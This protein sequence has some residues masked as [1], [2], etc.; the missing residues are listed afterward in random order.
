[1]GFWD[2]EKSAKRFLKM[3]SLYV[4]GNIF[5]LFNN[6]HIVVS[7]KMLTLYLNGISCTRNFENRRIETTFGELKLIKI[8]RITRL[9]LTFDEILNSFGLIDFSS[10]F[11]FLRGFICIS[12]QRNSGAGYLLMKLYSYQTFQAKVLQSCIKNMIYALLV[13]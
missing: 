1:M 11:F 10:L 13:K 6:Q 3:L 7:I 12:F 2:Q 4:C 8:N 9:L 5:L